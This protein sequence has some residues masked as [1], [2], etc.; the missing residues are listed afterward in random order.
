VSTEVHDLLIDTAPGPSH[1]LD[2]RVLVQRANHLRWSRRAWIGVTSL[3]VVVA[4]AV[5]GFLVLNTGP[6]GQSR[7]P[8]VVSPAADAVSFDQN[9]DTV[10]LPTDWFRTSEPL[11]PQLFDPHEILAAGTFPLETAAGTSVCVGD[12][13]PARALAVMQAA[14]AFFWIVEW[15]TGQRPGGHPSLADTKPRP[16]QFTPDEFAAR[17][18]VMQAFPTLRSRALDFNDRGRIFSVYVVVGSA[19]SASREQ[20]MYSILDSLRFAPR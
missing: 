2:M 20:Q 4:I 3:G 11:A 14:D 10:E 18:C 19:V 8:T 1:E 13:P 15:S 16:A 7:D 5:G 6:G 12:A 9:G 17:D